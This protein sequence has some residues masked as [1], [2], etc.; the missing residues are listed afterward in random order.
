MAR[1]SLFFRLHVLW[2]RVLTS[3]VSILD[4][5]Y[6]QPKPIQHSFKIKIPATTSSQKGFI[7]LL[8]YTPELSSHGNNPRPVVVNFHGGGWIFGSPQMD[9]RWASRVVQTGAVVVSVGYRLAPEHPFPTPLEDC[10]DA[11]KWVYQHADRYNLD[12]SRIVLSGFSAGGNMVFAAAI[13]ATG[14]FAFPSSSLESSRSIPFLT[15]RVPWKRNMRGI[16]L[17]RS[18]APRQKVGINCSSMLTLA[19]TR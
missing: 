16:R 7:E 3:L 1:S 17:L 15:A 6:S 14:G 11:I 13:K 12:T 9:S 10:V 19:P 8:F 5:Y 18:I 4:R 2:A